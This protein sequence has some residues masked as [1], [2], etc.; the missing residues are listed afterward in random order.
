MFRIDPNPTFARDVADQVLSRYLGV[1][2]AVSERPAALV[3]PVVRDAVDEAM[4]RG[5]V[6]PQA[7]RRL[8][9]AVRALWQQAGYT[10]DYA[11]WI[12]AA[13]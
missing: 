11:A 12:A 1:G 2:E 8:G 5:P 7:Q 3:P 9:E 10:G 13:R 4:R 6:A